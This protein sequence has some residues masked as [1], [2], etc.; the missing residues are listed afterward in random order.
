MK[1]LQFIFSLIILV[2]VGLF[3][4]G[5]FLIGKP[6]DLGVRYTKEEYKTYVQKAQTEV[7]PVKGPRSP[8][9]SIVYSGKKDLKQSFTQEEIS[10]RINYAMWKYMPVANT[11]VRI[12]SDGSVEFSGNVIMNRL[13]G[14]IEREGM[15]Q[16]TMADVEKGLKYIKF[17]K[18]NFPLYVKFNGAVASN[19]LALSIQQMTVGKFNVPLTTVHANETATSVYNSVVSKVNGL[20]VKSVTFSDRGMQFDGTVPE[21]MMV[22]TE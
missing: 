3:V 14:F 9:E 11:Q 15:G 1:L 7:V 12:N 5:Y 17:L 21:K 16:Y 13:P 8:A 2:I 18:F 10:A 19:N 6:K 4:L 22:E 20:S